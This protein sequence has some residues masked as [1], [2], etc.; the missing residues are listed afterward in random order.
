MNLFS[1]TDFKQSIDNELMQNTKA[2]DCEKV[3]SQF[4]K[5]ILRG[6]EY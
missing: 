6:I 2:K 1:I 3:L 5:R 4:H